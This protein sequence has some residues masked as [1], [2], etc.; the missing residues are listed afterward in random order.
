MAAR[1]VTLKQIKSKRACDDQ[2]YLFREL[3]GPK[4]HLLTVKQ[5]RVFNEEMAGARNT[6]TIDS[7]ERVLEAIRL[8]ART[9]NLTSRAV[10]FAKAYNSPRK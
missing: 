4:V 3:F 7:D 6:G 8:K 5:Q 10:A 1:Y 2:V 9:E